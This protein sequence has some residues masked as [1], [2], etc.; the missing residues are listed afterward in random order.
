VLPGLKGLS[1]RLFKVRHR[2]PTPVFCPKCKSHKIKLKESYGILP[3]VYKCNECGYE[4][5]L[6]LELE[7][8]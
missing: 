5:H 1:D 7:E 2:A 4:G 6:V 8:E 3:H